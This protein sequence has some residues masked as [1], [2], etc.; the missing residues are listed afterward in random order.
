MIDYV[1]KKL[2][3]YKAKQDADKLN[4]GKAYANEGWIHC[5]S[6]GERLMHPDTVTDKFKED[7]L[8]CNEELK[9]KNREQLPIITLHDLRHTVATLLYDRFKVPLER[10]AEILRHSDAR[11]TRRTYTHPTIVLQKD[12]LKNINNI[13]EHK[14]AN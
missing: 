13:F 12:P 4:Y 6:L 14:E 7:I 11:F 8:S 2:K 9:N 1:A 3:K 5:N 10:V